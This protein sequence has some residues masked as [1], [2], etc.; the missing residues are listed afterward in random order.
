MIPVQ[1][2]YGLKIPSWKFWT[3]VDNHLSRQE[4]ITRRFGERL[5]CLEFLHSCKN[6]VEKQAGKFIQDS[7]NV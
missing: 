2:S 3:K 1:S 7:H 6:C 5:W 4:T